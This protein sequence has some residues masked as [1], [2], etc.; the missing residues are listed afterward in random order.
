M[1]G[2]LIT[3]ALL[4]AGCEQIRELS[5]PPCRWEA[6]VEDVGGIAWTTRELKCE[7]EG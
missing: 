3:L 6:G 7:D 5:N 4:V 2:V 1:K